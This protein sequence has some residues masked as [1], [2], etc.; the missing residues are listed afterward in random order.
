MGKVYLA[1]T[2]SGR[3]IVVKVI[4]ADHVRQDEYRARFTR[5]VAAARRIG[6]FHTAQVVDADT[7]ADEPWIASAY[8]SGPSLY[9]AVFAHGPLPEGSL[10]VLAVGLAEGLEAIH[11]HGLVHR[12]LKPANII[13]ADD[14]PRIID[15]GISRPT[16]DTRITHSGALLGTPAYMAPEQAEGEPP[17]PAVDVFSLGTVLHF[18]ATGTNPF[19]ARTVMAG[20][21]LL[22]G[23]TPA[24]ADE[25][26][27]E[28][29]DLITRCWNQQPAKRP[30]LSEVVDILGEVGSDRVWPPQPHSTVV[31]AEVLEKRFV[32][33]KSLYDEDRYSAALP[34]F[35]Q[36]LPQFR[37]YLG[38]DHRRTLY[39][40]YL[41]AHCQGQTGK[42]E[43]A[44]A[45][46]RQLLP[47]LTRVQGP[48][49][50]DTLITRQQIGYCHGRTGN[51]HAALE[52]FR[53]LLSDHIRIL[54]PDY[55]D[56][57]TTRHN[58]AL[59]TYESGDVVKAV[60]LVTT[61]VRDRMRILGPN[62][63]DTQ[64]SERMLRR[65][66]AELPEE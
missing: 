38:D 20:L 4:R 36:L 53:Q 31:S 64:T 10:R 32:A 19:E 11:E 33:F 14:G 9:Q 3:K 51:P 16:N 25:V 50:P 34:G 23:P 26:P 15:F 45:T 17:A 30:S 48:D 13:L 5:E 49:H 60:E 12:D 18:A 27:K 21:R 40:R 44:L 66:R 47:D 63:P 65:W 46:Y 28:L 2:G 41:I 58:L 42:P 59:Y 7:D 57:L 24:V 1:H 35:E 43:A 6:G 22:I 54:G 52:E 8:I 37:G 39:T 55:P 62:H 29:R 56:T 61:L